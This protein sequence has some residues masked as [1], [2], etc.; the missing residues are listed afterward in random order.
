MWGAIT[1]FLTGG[2]VKSIENIA[3]EWIETDKEKA[4]AKALFIKTL[5]PNG[6]M[7]RDISRKVS[8]A[9][10]VY[11]FTTMLLVL[12]LSFNIGNVNELKDAIKSLTELFVPITSMFTL[13]VGSSFGVNLT[14]SVKGK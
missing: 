2:A 12:C 13:I 1:N 8:T 7:R 5:D 10:L 9:Y 6:R 11:L 3:T 4:E 14:N